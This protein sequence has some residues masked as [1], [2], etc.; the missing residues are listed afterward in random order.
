MLV[1][2]GACEI[3][4]DPIVALWDLAPLQVI[5]E[6]AGGVFTDFDGGARIDGGSAISSNGLVHQAALTILRGGPQ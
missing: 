1:A 4:L 3:G 2:E 6:E 5:V